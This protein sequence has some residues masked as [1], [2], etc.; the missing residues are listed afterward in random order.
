MR[1][2]ES[3]CR[4][5]RKPGLVGWCIRYVAS[6]AR[7][8]RKGRVCGP[9]CAVSSCTQWFRSTDL[10]V[11]AAAAA[12]RPRLATQRSQDPDHPTHSRPHR[13]SDFLQRHKPRVKAAVSIRPQRVRVQRLRSST[14]ARDEGRT[15]VNSRILAS[16]GLHHLAERASNELTQRVPN[17]GR[18]SQPKVPTSLVARAV[19]GCGSIRRE[20]CREALVRRAA[21]RR[22][23][24]TAAIFFKLG[25][26]MG[27]QRARRLG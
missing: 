21:A 4:R 8:M 15:F 13:P 18:Q 24:F 16:G 11:R 1:G 25:E 9:C 20:D 10:W 17:E 27:A 23:S 26:D 6:A 19:V 14:R 2:D 7:W 3:T 12:T 22:G 5:K